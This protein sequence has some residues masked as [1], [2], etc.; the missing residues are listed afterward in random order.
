MVMVKPALAYLDV[1]AEVRRTFDVPVAAY[2]VSGEYAMVKAAAQLG[3]IDGAAVALEHLARDQAGRRRHHPHL[4]RTR[5]RRAPASVTVMPIWFER[6]QARIPGGVNSPVRAFGSVGGEPFFVARAHGAYLVDTDGSEYLDYVQSWG[7]SI[8]G[9]AHPA[10]VEAV[11]RAAARR[12]L[13]RRADDARGRAR[14]GDLRARAVGR[15]GAARVV[16]HRSRDDRGAARAR[17]DRPHQDREV[18]GLLPRPPRRAARRRP[19]SGVATLGLPGSAGVTPGTD[20]RHDRRALQRPRRA[21][22]ACSPSTAREIAA[23][24]VEPVAANMGLVA[25]EPRI[26]STGCASG[27]TR[28][29]ALLVFDEV[30]TG[31]RVGARRRAGP[32]RHH[33]RSLDLRQGHRRRAPARRG[34]RTGRAHGRARAAR[35][36]V[37]G[38]HALGEP[39]RDRGRSRRAGRARR[40]R[41]RRSSRQTAASGSATACATRSPTRA[42]P[43]RSPRA[44]TLVGRVLR[45]RAR[46]RTTTRRA[47]ADHERY[48][49]VL[50]RPARPRRVLRAERLRDDVPEPRPHRR[51]HR[52]TIEASRSLEDVAGRRGNRRFAVPFAR[53]RGTEQRTVGGHRGRVAER[54]AACVDGHSGGSTRREARRCRLPAS[55]RTGRALSRG[56]VR[57]SRAF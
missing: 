10:V 57:G 51:R 2:H 45:R 47:A 44:F 23:V 42:S 32:L 27:C 56:Q 7:A 46:A 26:S 55:G 40:R 35:R 37:P 8:L 54:R 19:G 11:Q 15:E 49:R 34:R 41:V 31:F 5:G 13:V 36:R 43:R 17:R 3:W 1:I 50:P 33:A 25:A 29:G 30:I 4:L 16:G 21:R 18:R 12:H 38:G 22:R 28:H 53:R 9:H 14:R 52:P 39:A 24:L 48:A 20:G 6:A